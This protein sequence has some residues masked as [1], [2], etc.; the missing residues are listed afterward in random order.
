MKR[1][2]TMQRKPTG[3][4]GA[5]VDTSGPVL[6]KGGPSVVFVNFKYLLAVSTETNEIEW[7]LPLRSLIHLE[8]SM[9]P[10]TRTP[11]LVAVTDNYHLR[12]T[13]TLRS[14]LQRL[15]ECISSLAG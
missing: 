1:I 5:S 9:E 4:F 14:G 2:G 6:S 13:C 3:L 11:I 7:A 15:K 8:V 12:V 10:K